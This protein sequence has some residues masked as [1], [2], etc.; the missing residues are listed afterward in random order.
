M[1]DLLYLLRDIC[2][3]RRGPQDV[4]Y[5]PGLLAVICMATLLLQLS[6]AWVFDVKGDALLAGI[7]GLA[8]NLGLLHLVLTLRGLTTRFVQAACALLGCAIFF[9]LLVLPI[10][11]LMGGLQT[12]APDHMTPVQALL[13]LVALPIV[14]WKLVVDAHILR[15]SLNLPFFGGLAVALFWVLATYLLA[16]ALR[17]PVAA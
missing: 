13:A 14:A 5:S 4:P 3:L 2:Q 15:H 8:F 9:T 6:I 16:V 10:T 7:L 12:A 1:R 11:L 17:D